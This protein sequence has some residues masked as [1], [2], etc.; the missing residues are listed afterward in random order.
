MLME[1]IPDMAKE[2]RPGSGPAPEDGA[3]AG[4]IGLAAAV[5][6][7]AGNFFAGWSGSSSDTPPL[8]GGTVPGSSPASFH[9]GAES[10]E[11]WEMLMFTIL[12]AVGLVV[13]YMEASGV[14]NAPYS[15]F[16]KE[17]WTTWG[18]M[19]TRPGML[20]IEGT[21]LAVISALYYIHGEL[22]PYHCVTY[23][24]FCTIYTKRILEILFV[25]KYSG[26]I[27]KTAVFFF[28]RNSLLLLNPLH[29]P[30]RRQQ[31]GSPN[32]TNPTHR[33]CTNIKRLSPLVTSEV[34]YTGHP[35]PPR[36]I[37]QFDLDYFYAQAEEVMDRSLKDVP[38]AIQQKHIVVTCNYEARRNGVKK[39][40][41]LTDAQKTCPNLVIR[42]GEDITVYR[43]FSQCIQRVIKTIVN[44]PKAA[45]DEDPGDGGSGG[46][47]LGWVVPV[48]KLGLDE[49]FLDVSEMIR[50]HVEQ[51]DFRKQEGELKNG[52]IVGEGEERSNRRRSTS[53]VP[54]GQVWP[55]GEIVFKLPCSELRNDT[56]INNNTSTNS[57]KRKQS[58]LNS[59]NDQYIQ[60]ILDS[61]G[62][63]GS[64]FSYRPGTFAS[65]TLVVDSDSNG[66]VITDTNN[67]TPTL[68]TSKE[69]EINNHDH[70]RLRYLQIASHLSAHL[71]RAVKALTG[72]T[73]SSGIS[74]SKLFA[75]LA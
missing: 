53:M 14:F 11:R 13:G 5:G 36:A 7:A 17:R 43:R 18:Y 24:I 8:A 67:P 66:I 60:T 12:S 9:I 29:A 39:L 45:N 41:L 25:H 1:A 58:N 27:S 19:P 72:F 3:A 20:I 22:D 28:L 10:E 61:L 4:G 63:W 38:L 74:E 2:G 65:E 50:R 35:S 37:I 68:K 6:E 42:S 46:G 69:K 21:T 56:N 31:L 59:S 40:Q 73:T 33:L 51:V 54:D 44:G 71:R 75:K 57:N 70:G 47:E 62:G 55:D 34:T 49:L 16:R 64:G 15:K 48:E 23:A 30:K 26:P 32:P 52:D